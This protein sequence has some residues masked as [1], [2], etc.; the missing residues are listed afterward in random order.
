MSKDYLARMQSAAARMQALIEAL[1][2]Y[3]RV[4]TKAQPAT[5]VDLRVTAAEVISDLETQIEQQQG[6]VT[7]G[8]LDVVPADPLQMHQLLQNLI[9]NALKFHRP[10][11]A[12]AVHVAGRWLN[13]VARP[14][15]SPV[16]NSARTP[17]FMS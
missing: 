12:P 8:N 5:P 1:L 2:A 14:N 13:A 15:A 7:L 4:T 17:E 10:E 6:I 9:G 3:S 16:C 11:T